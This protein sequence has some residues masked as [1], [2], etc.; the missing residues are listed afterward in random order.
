MESKAPHKAPITVQTK[1]IS[2]TVPCPLPSHH[3][4]IAPAR[5]PMVKPHCHPNRQAKNKPI[6]APTRQCLRLSGCLAASARLLPTSAI[7]STTSSKN[8][9]IW[10]FMGAFSNTLSPVTNTGGCVLP[11]N[12]PNHTFPPNKILMRSLMVG[13]QQETHCLPSFHTG[14]DW[15][16]LSDIVPGRCNTFV[17]C[18]K[19]IGFI[20]FKLY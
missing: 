10:A 18:G 16:S 7:L 15:H 11:D 19:S 12:M 8:A 9:L 6:K 2:S 5:Q 1:S 14:N 13:F 17:D 3:S 20:S 4:L